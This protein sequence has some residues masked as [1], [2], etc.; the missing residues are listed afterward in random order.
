MTERPAHLT[1][2]NRVSA[3]VLLIGDDNRL[4]LIHGQDP[5]SPERGSWHFPVGGGVESG[6]TIAQ[7]AAREVAEETGIGDLRLGPHIWNRLV[8]FEFNG[9]WL[10]QRER[11]FVG[12]TSTTVVSDA[13]F[14]ELERRQILGLRWWNAQELAATPDIVYP[15][16]LRTALPDLIKGIYPSQPVDIGE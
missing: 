10:V 8:E 12:W 11:Y 16:T 14:T 4:L 9:H 6:E 5:A 15:T 7:A 1:V 13:G 3:R 2:L